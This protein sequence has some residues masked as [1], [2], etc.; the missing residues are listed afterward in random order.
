MR[1]PTVTV[2]ISP[3]RSFCLEQIVVVQSEGMT[4][5]VG[6]R[7]RAIFCHRVEHPADCVRRSPSSYERHPTATSVKGVRGHDYAHAQA[8][9]SRIIQ[10]AIRSDGNIERGI[11]FRNCFDNGRDGGRRYYGGRC[12]N[13]LTPVPEGIRDA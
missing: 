7:V 9:T 2:T 6:D 8:D 13:R 3:R 5:F 12:N 1:V 10:S 4:Y 11:V